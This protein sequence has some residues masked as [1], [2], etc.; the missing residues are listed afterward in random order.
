[1]PTDMPIVD[2]GATATSGI[3]AQNGSEYVIAV[4]NGTFSSDPVAQGSLFMTNVHC[5]IS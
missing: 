2:R 5:A 1:M 3:R 4:R